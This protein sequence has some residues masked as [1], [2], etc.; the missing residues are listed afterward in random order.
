MEIAAS[1]QGNAW[2]AV[3]TVKIEDAIYVWHVFQK[4]STKG[5]ATRQGKSASL[6]GG[7][8]T[9]NGIIERQN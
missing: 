8:R 3:Y 1:P 5:L 6:R 9:P 2:R 4:K 7:S